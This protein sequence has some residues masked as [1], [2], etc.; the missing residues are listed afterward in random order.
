MPLLAM[1]NFLRTQDERI[2]STST[3]S[4][5]ANRKHPRSSVCYG[6]WGSI[7]FLPL[8][9]Q[10]TRHWGKR[11]R[12]HPSKTCSRHVLLF[13]A[14]PSEH[15]RANTEDATSVD[16]GVTVATAGRTARR[17]TATLLAARAHARAHCAWTGASCITPCNILF[18]RR[19]HSRPIGHVWTASSGA[20]LPSCYTTRF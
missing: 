6:L 12:V 15:A 18:R 10:R 17:F 16:V 5:R 8:Q 1:V 3:L 7:R 9:V 13:A 11:Q 19:L 4:Y 2:G 14:H 20:V